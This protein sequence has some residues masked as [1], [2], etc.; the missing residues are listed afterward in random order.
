M[1]R[2]AAGVASQY[3]CSGGPIW[4]LVGIARLVD[5][6]AYGRGP[7]TTALESAAMIDAADRDRF[8][9]AGFWVK[10]TIEALR[11][12]GLDAGT[13]L[14][15]TGLDGSALNDPDA[16]FPSEKVNQLWHLAVAY[17]GN[18]AV[19]LIASAVP[20]PALFDVVGYA[21]MSAP[22]L[23][24]ILDRALRYLRIV[25]DAASFRVGGDHEGYRFC[26]ELS[27]D[28]GAVPWQ[29]YTFDLLSLL[30]FLRWVLVCD[31]QPL[32][33]E[34]T[35]QTNRSLEQCRELL[36]FPVR[37]ESAANALLFSHSDVDLALPTAHPRL[38][39]V[40]E[41]IAD[42]YLARLNH[43]QTSARVRAVILKC[44]PD[45]EPRRDSVARGLGMSERTLQR[46]LKTEGYSFQQLLDDARKELAEKYMERE[47]MSLAEAAYLL[48]FE[49][50]SSFFRAVKRWFGTTPRGYRLR[51]AGR[52]KTS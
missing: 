15:D 20:R 29:R 43:L 42:E 45:G 9:S 51:S 8:K 11:V 2:E 3:Y 50:Q 26:L 17:S 39:S 49:D 13:L 38:A 46:R 12:E 41:R 32:A 48:G 34:L 4:I 37:F 18:E 40:H 24:G 22:D 10:G 23:R 21:M 14:R 19:G 27:S 7:S 47:D 33:L 25:S 28:H 30:S 16:R 31:L 44:L 35:T 52:S 6:A 36:G 5:F 1:G